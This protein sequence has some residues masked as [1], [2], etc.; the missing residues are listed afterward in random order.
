MEREELRGH[1][2]P[3]TCLKY[4]QSKQL[5][6]SGSED[7]SVRLWDSRTSRSVKCFHNCFDSEIEAVHFAY[8]SEHILFAVTCSS[9]YSFDLRKECVLDSQPLAIV[10]NAFSEIS[11]AAFAPKDNL[12]AIAD[13]SDSIYL[14][15][16]NTDG[17][18]QSESQ[19]KLRKVHSNSIG[20]LVF[21]EKK[22]ELIS[23]GFDFLLCKWDID[24]AKPIKRGEFKSYEGFENSNQTLN[25][26]FITTLSF[27]P[28]TSIVA[29]GAG[30]GSIR[31][32][33][34]A[35][36]K[37]TTSRMAHAAMITSLQ[38]TASTIF[39]GGN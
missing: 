27:L 26:P 30:D 33:H 16:I 12:A 29:S 10:G 32:F 37:E 28:G 21:A 3:V 31:L 4:N 9:L 39:T 23:G 11:A 20:A 38:A 34:A 5:L 8:K 19:K 17:T 35:D 15:E 36:L 13:D 22:R 18:F 24:N 2:A 1:R 7:R 6:G 25:P 14:I